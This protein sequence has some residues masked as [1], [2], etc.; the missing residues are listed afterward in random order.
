MSD[1]RVE[2]ESGAREFAAVSHGIEKNTLPYVAW[3]AGFD[4][5]EGLYLAVVIAQI[6]ADYGTSSAERDTLKLE[7]ERLTKILKREFNENDELGAEYLGITMVREEN[8]KL[9]TAVVDLAGALKP[10]Q[11]LIKKLQ[12]GK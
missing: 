10:H 4:C 12:E 8:Q 2:R 6:E 3:K 9:R 1:Y 5:A 11:P 7:V